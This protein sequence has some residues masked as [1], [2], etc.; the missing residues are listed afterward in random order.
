MG[1]IR[2]TRK[3]ISLALCDAFRKD[4]TKIKDP[5]RESRVFLK[6]LL[7]TGR[8]EIFTIAMCYCGNRMSVTNLII[9]IL[10]NADHDFLMKKIIKHKNRKP[11]SIFRLPE[12]FII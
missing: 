7:E 12:R 9:Y 11:R 3:D 5:V 10:M 8:Y 6:R 1:L 2:K 4:F